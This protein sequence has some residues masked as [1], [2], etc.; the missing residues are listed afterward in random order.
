M[1]IDILKGKIMEKDSES[2]TP[3][4]RQLL[5]EHTELNVSVIALSRQLPI[6][7]LIKDFLAYH[8]LPSDAVFAPLGNGL[9]REL[10]SELT[11]QM[12]RFYSLIELERMNLHFKYGVQN[13]DKLS[14][15][16]R[17]L[18]DADLRMYILREDHYP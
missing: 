18:F 12:N 13:A 1:R 16:R 10:W 15:E 4:V 9:S 17:A 7:G 5:L 11:E 2:L 6:C 14:P 3:R 8:N